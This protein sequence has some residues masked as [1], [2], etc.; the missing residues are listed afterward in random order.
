MRIEAGNTYRIYGKM[1]SMRRMAPVSGSDFCV[2]LIHADMYFIKCEADAE[3]LE[4]EIKF[5]N[6]Q[7]TFEARKIK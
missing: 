5:M 6:T 7:G 2:N 1:G 3:K 4:R